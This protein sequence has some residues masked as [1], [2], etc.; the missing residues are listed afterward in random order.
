[1][2]PHPAGAF[3]SKLNAAG[4]ALVYSTYLGGNNLSDQGKAIAVDGSG[5]AYVAGARGILDEHALYR[6]RLF[7]TVL[8]REGRSLW[9][10]FSPESDSDDVGEAVATDS[11]GNTYVAGHSSSTNY[12]AVAALQSTRTG[13]ENAVVTKIA[14]LTDPV[15]SFTDPFAGDSIDHLFWSAVAQDAEISEGDGSVNI[16][17]LPNLGTSVGI[18]TTKSVYS[19]RNSQAWVKV[20]EVVGPQGNVNNQFSLQRDWNNALTWWYENGRLHAM[21]FVNGQQATLA[22]LIYSPSAHPWWR[23]R[24]T[25]GTVYWETSTNGSTWTIHASA[26]SSGLF[27]LDAVNVVLVARTWG[28]GSPDPGFA[29]YANLNVLP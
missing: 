6:Y 10:Y 1:M 25:F 12:P 7:A 27:P 14:L 21:Y 3:V 13:I 5:N 2:E 26:S 29:R 28:S 8:N 24:E 15:S 4:S 22:S 23:I 19:L 9:F 11:I 16:G 18:L 17:L 20:E